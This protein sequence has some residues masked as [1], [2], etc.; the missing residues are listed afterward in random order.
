MRIFNAVSCMLLIHF[1]AGVGAV[2]GVSQ[3]HHEFY[4]GRGDRYLMGDL[5]TGASPC[6][7]GHNSNTR[8]KQ[9]RIVSS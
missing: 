9:R 4:V 1:E 5:V 6:Q 8:I 3:R 2:D 7:R